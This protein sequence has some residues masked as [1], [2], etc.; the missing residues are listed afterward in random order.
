MLTESEY[1]IPR[2]YVDTFTC[3]LTSPISEVQFW[4]RGNCRIS[5]VPTTRPFLPLRAAADSGDVNSTSYPAQTLCRLTGGP[6]TQLSIYV[7]ICRSLQ[8]ADTADIASR[9]TAC[10][11]HMNSFSG[12]MQSKQRRSSSIYLMSA[13]LAGGPA[14][15]LFMTNQFRS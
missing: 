11:L 1:C 3:Y 10:I 5:T 14:F 15:R 7:W 4:L 13:L 9:W 12:V 8:T 2:N 6:V